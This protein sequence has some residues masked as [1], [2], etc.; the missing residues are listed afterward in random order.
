MKKSLILGLV[1]VFFLFDIALKKVV[2]TFSAAILSGNLSVHLPIL[3]FVCFDLAYVENTGMAWGLFSSFQF[4]ILLLRM[5]LIAIIGFGM[6]K[7]KSIQSQIVPYALIFFGAVG[8][9]ID[10]FVYGHVID[11]LHFTFWGNS[12]GIFNIADA[13]IFLGAIFIIFSRNRPYAVKE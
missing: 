4:L 3:P 10:T 11:M 6:M 2:V 13:M 9:V 7:S 8:N 5:V 1:F 12:Y